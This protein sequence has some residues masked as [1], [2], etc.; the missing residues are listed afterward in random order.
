VNDSAFGLVIPYTNSQGST[1]QQSLAGIDYISIRL[2]LVQ[3]AILPVNFV[4]FIGKK[5]L[6][7]AA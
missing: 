1:T 4:V 2:V 7:F 3:Q 5:H 6:A